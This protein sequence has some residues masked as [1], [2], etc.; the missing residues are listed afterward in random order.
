MKTLLGFTLACLLTV[1]TVGAALSQSS[2]PAPIYTPPT[3]AHIPRTPQN[4]FLLENMDQFQ[5]P[6]SGTYY[7]NDGTIGT[8][9]QNGRGTYGGFS[10]NRGR[11]GSFTQNRRGTSGQ[12]QDNRGNSG[13]WHGSR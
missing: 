8:Y 9:W 4:N 1:G 7:G 3:T 6:K 12:W 2:Y 5:R 13:S 11:S 10:D